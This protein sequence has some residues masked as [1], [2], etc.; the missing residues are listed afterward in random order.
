MSMYNQSR[1]HWEWEEK[2]TVN[3][4]LISTVSR[5]NREKSVFKVSIEIL[6]IILSA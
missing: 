1:V 4:M 3:D 6:S 5:I 2:I